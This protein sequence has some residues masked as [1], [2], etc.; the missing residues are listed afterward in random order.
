M[1]LIL[2]GDGRDA[3]RH[4][5]RGAG[6]EAFD[7]ESLRHVEAVLDVLVLHVVVHVVAE[8]RDVNS[9]VVEFLAHALPGIGSDA[10]LPFGNGLPRLVHLFLLFRRQRRSSA[11]TAPSGR[12]RAIG[13]LRRLPLRP[14]PAERLEARWRARSASLS[15]P[16]AEAAAPEVGHGRH[17]SERFAVVRH[18][19]RLTQADVHIILNNHQRVGDAVGNYT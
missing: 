2:V 5:Q 6:G 13:R 11:A 1:Q 9:G 3:L 18:Q 8:Q 15:A 16:P 7:A 19:L 4:G 10:G 14:R 17:S 12:R